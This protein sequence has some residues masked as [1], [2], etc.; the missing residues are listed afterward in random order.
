MRL[1]AAGDGDIEFLYRLYASTRSDEMALVDWTEA[2]KEEFLRMQFNA[3]HL[4]YHDQFKQASFDILVLEVQAI[5]RLYVDRREDE[6]RV[7]DI[8]LLPEF[9]GRGIGGEIMQALIDEAA[10]GNRSV[11]IHVEHNNPALNLYRRLGFGRVSDEG[12]YYFMKWN[13]PDEAGSADQENT[14]S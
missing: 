11:T 9:R 10:A 12:V 5:G 14:A 2:Q 13:P 1:R 4:Y 7:I 3:Q 8:A 6:I